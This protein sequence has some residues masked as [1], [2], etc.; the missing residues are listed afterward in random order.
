MPKQTVDNYLNFFTT[1]TKIFHSCEYEN[2]SLF[3][4]SSLLR[5]SYDFLKENSLIKINDNDKDKANLISQEDI[6]TLSKEEN[7][8]VFLVEFKEPSTF[9]LIINLDEKTKKILLDYLDSTNYNIKFFINDLPNKSTYTFTNYFLDE[10]NQE[11]IEEYQ[12]KNQYS[13]ILKTEPKFIFINIDEII[14]LWYNQDDESLF[15]DEELFYLILLLTITDQE[16]LKKCYQKLKVPTEIKKTL[17]KLLFNI[18]DSS[19]RLQSDYQTLLNKA[20]KTEKIKLAKT[21]VNDGMDLAKIAK[22]TKLSLKEIR[23][24]LS[25]N[26]YKY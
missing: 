7:K 22:Y 20:L 19:K 14:K 25:D 2:L 11:I 21:M 17:K 8:I 9:E 5:I 26:N 4:L 16:Q 15:L 10:F 3:F 1:I 18:D 12:Y 24:L 23:K 13:Y 6:L